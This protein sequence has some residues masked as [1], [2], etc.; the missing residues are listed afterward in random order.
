MYIFFCVVVRDRQTAGTQLGLENRFIYSF[1]FPILTSTMRLD[2]I[3]HVSNLT[4][5]STLFHLRQQSLPMSYPLFV[6]SVPDM[7]HHLPKN[8]IQMDTDNTN[9]TVC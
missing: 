3:C 1:G 6:H 4:V 9:Q 2:R 5:R 7:M 8:S